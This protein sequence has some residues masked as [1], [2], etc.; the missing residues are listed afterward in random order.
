MKRKLLLVA[1]MLPFLGL[2]QQHSTGVVNLGTEM[3]VKFDTDPTTVT[4]TLTGPST[5]WFGVGIN[6]TSMASG[7]CVIY[8]TS[9]SDRKLIGQTTPSVDASQDWTVTSNTTSG[10][11]RTIVATRA[12]D[13]GDANDYTFTNSANSIN[14]IWA[15]G[16]STTL[17]YHASRGG[18]VS[19]NLALGADSFEKIGFKMYPNPAQDQLFLTLPNEVSSATMYIFDMQGRK[20]MNVDLNANESSIGIS[21]L[22]K[23][24]YVVK[25]FTDITDVAQ[26]LIIE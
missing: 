22:Q 23:G 14:L 16:S 13:T 17:A 6:A 4:M 9:L 24:H 2:A 1:A 18:G 20:V 15:V 26:S 21:S 11:V 19:A 8:T 10:G 3:S 25:I 12:L 7:D 5:K